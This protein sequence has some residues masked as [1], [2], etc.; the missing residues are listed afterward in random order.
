MSYIPRHS[1]NGGAAGDPTGRTLLYE[2]LMSSYT[3]PFFANVRMQSM[4]WAMWDLLRWV[5]DDNNIILPVERKNHER[6]VARNL[7]VAFVG[8]GVLL[9]TTRLGCVD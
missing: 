9:K 8:C 5:T 3:F 4:E 2:V 7:L 1:S 6:C